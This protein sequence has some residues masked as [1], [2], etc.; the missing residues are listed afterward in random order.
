MKEK[1]ICL[2]PYS[3]TPVPVDYIKQTYGKWINFDKVELSVIH[4]GINEDQLPYEIRDA[5]IINSYG[6]PR[7]PLTR[8]LLENA[9]NLKLIQQL[10]VGYDDID[11]IAAKELGI[12]VCNTHGSNSSTVAE[13][14]IMMILMLLRKALYAD[15]TTRKG[16]WHQVTLGTSDELRELRDKKLGLIGLGSIGYE[17]ARLAKSFNA[18]I[19]YYKRNKLPEDMEKAINARYV[20]LKT[21]IKEADIISLHVPLTPETKNIIGPREIAKMKK[22]AIIVNTS[23][24][25]LIDEI[26]LKE[27]LESR[28]LGGA[29]LDVFNPEPPKELELMQ[30]DRLVVSPHIS[31]ISQEWLLRAF[32]LCG[33]NMARVIKGEEPINRVY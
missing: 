16:E 9:P 1:I 33:E 7:I 12:P 25:E 17:V 14:T 26:A 28:E 21:L 22:D 4:G 2:T 30:F 27:A 13:H 23:R 18:E 8:L 24:G 31:G 3:K 10:G 19:L 5:T 11:I 20:D 32:K 29:A 6:T 15:K